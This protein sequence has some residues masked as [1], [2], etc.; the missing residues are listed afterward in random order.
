VRPTL[1]ADSGRQ[2]RLAL[3]TIRL[4]GFGKGLLAYGA[5]VK[6][7]M[8]QSQRNTLK[9]FDIPGIAHPVWLRPGTSDWSVMEQI[10]LNDEYGFSSWPEHEEAISAHYRAITQQLKVPV[11]VDCG[12][13]IGLSAIWFAT[14]F[15]RARIYAIEPEPGNFEILTRNLAPVENAVPLQ[16]AISDRDTRASLV[17]VYD[18]PWAWQIQES[19]LG[20]IRTV[21][22]PALLG[23]CPDGEPLIVKFDIEGSELEL[24]RSNAAWVERVPLIVFELHDHLGG[25]KGTGHAVFTHLTTH[26]RDYMQRGENMFSFAHFLNKPKSIDPTARMPADAAPGCGRNLTRSLPSTGI[27]RPHPAVADA[28]S[29]STTR[30]PRS[31][32]SVQFRRS[33]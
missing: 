26:R 12:A 27:K 1:K 13:N 25:W 15:P 21:T 23:C 8:I 20:E 30:K 6:H 7:R 3:R 9:R 28:R 5:Y 22:I 14:K 16:A 2:L 33:K 10:F 31:R 19:E 17:N 11:I 4:F 29:H 32:C 24:F 18:E